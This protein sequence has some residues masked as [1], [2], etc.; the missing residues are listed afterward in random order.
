MKCLRIYADETGESHLA[1]ID[2]PLVP[3]ELFPGIPPIYL[4]A[5]HAA[6]SVRFA[7]VPP[8]IREAG[9][10]VT[11]VR[12]LVIWLTGWTEFETSDGEKRRCEPGTVVLAEDT[13]GKGH[14]T[15]G[16]SDGQLAMFGPV[17]DGLSGARLSRASSVRFYP[18]V[19]A[20]P[21]GHCH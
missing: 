5:Q 2:I 18:L 12:Q 10:H 8:G 6:S 19:S 7:W 9:W 14:I 20:S 1:D 15:R 11:P 17:P 16:P 21:L 13:S 4:S 3:V